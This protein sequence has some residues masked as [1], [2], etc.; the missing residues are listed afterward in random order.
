MTIRNVWLINQYTSTPKLGGGGNRSYFIAKELV[1]NGHNVTLIT[2]SYS[3]VPKRNYKIDNHFHFEKEENIN[4][5]VIKNVVYESGKSVLRILSMLIFWLKLYFLPLKKITTPDIII[6]SSI[7][8]LPILNA[9]RIKS[10]YK[11]KP[12][13]ILEI[14]DIWPLSLV[15]LG[16]FSKY[17][18][19]LI[20]LS[21][22][23]KKAYI[24]SD[25]ITSV[26]PLANE[27]IYSITR[28]NVSFKHISNGIHLGSIQV[29]EPLSSEIKGLLPGGKFL[30]GYTGALGI[31]NA[32]DNFIDL[33]VSNRNDPNFYF[34]IVGDG[35]LKDSLKMKAIGLDNILF[36]DRI[37]KAQVQSV[38]KTFDLLYI[39]WHHSDIYKYGISANKI[40]DYMYSGKPILMVG[41]IRNTE[42]DI[43]NCGKVIYS[44]DLIEV[45]K[46]LKEFFNMSLDER[47]RYGNRGKD[48]IV[49]YKTYE[50]LT[51][52]YLE[53]FEEFEKNIK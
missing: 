21:W 39:A 26:L 10:I 45:N 27:H 30:I 37:P 50:Y 16:G 14:R 34:V 53:I 29:E 38:L 23:E 15:A 31:A 44:S 36:L 9:F 46:A 40:F 51:Q 49:K 32:M 25:Y 13:V 48:F 47:K 24:E 43:A 52:L 11:N 12:K 35:Y 8:L 3:H 41:N 6:V 33:A 1:R 2:S 7:S 5:V 19:L 17:N 28:S 20:F 22:I 42:I 4:L 18:P